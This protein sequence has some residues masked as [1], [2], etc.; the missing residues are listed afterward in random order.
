MLLKI[1]NIHVSKISCIEWINLLIVDFVG[2]PLSI[3]LAHSGI[4]ICELTLNGRYWF[5]SALDFFLSSTLPYS[6]LVVASTVFFSGAHISEPL[7]NLVGYGSWPMVTLGISRVLL[8]GR[9]CDC[10]PVPGLPA[11]LGGQL[12]IRHSPR[13]RV[14]QVFSPSSPPL[15]FKAFLLNRKNKRFRDTSPGFMFNFRL[16]NRVTNL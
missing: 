1:V 9:G 11:F 8:L 7:L 6:G 13:S 12:R 2:F 5:A 4:L 3:N 15:M 14:A 10:T 16:H